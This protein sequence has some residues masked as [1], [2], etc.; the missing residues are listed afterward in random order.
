ML[1][2]ESRSDRERILDMARAAAALP[3]PSRRQ[4]IAGLMHERLISRAEASVTAE[5]VFYAGYGDA[6][7]DYW[8]A[9]LFPGKSTADG[10]ASL[11]AAATS[12]SDQEYR[13][14]KV[15]LTAALTAIADKPARAM[16]EHLAADP[17]TAR[18]VPASLRAYL[19][20]GATPACPAPATPGP[21]V[22]QKPPGVLPTRRRKDSPQRDRVKAEMR[23]AVKAGSDVFGMKEE[24]M[25]ER[26]QASREVC[27]KARNE[28]EAE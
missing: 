25:K 20:L 13:R 17:D 5:E 4:R 15:H 24:E 26:F 16:A 14:A 7:G 3:E 10:L 27:R 22:A 9:W 28:L 2:K 21:G 11:I 6:P 1:E 8:C 23:A 18:F 12:S 19:E